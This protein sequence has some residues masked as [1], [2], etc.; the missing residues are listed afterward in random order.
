MT[1]VRQEGW[2]NRKL[3]L[4][5]LLL[6]LLLWLPQGYAQRSAEGLLE[7]G[8][9]RGVAVPIYSPAG[10]APSAVIYIESLATEYQRKG[11]FRIGV[12]PLW[13]MDGLTFDIRKP[14]AV[15]DSLAGLHKWLGADGAKRFKMQRVKLVATA[16]ATRLEAANARIAS[17]GCLD[18][19]NGV[20]L[21]I[22]TN[23]ISS[24]RAT[25]QLT[26]DN[27]GE[28]VMADGIISLKPRSN[29]FQLFTITQPVPKKPE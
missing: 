25:L 24:P 14:D 6:V 8:S 1:Q 21:T 23:R 16:A 12:L 3:R 27:S 26:G 22:G 9:A 4:L 15:A 20:T 28:L 17:A 13:V 7:G 5:A 19:Y 11:L 18:L 2:R 10:G 29:S